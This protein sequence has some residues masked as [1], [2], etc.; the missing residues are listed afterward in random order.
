MFLKYF[1]SLFKGNGRSETP[2]EKYGTVK[3]FNRKKGYGFI[4]ST[5]TTR[6]VFVHATDVKDK[7]SKGDEVRFH[8]EFND[9]GLQAKDVRVMQHS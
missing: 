1:S 5:E 3:F 4:V 9:K 2:M 7:I 8:I 6:E